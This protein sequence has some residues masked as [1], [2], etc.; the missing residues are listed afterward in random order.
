M[1]LSKIE[2]FGFKSFANKTVINF[3]EGIT[4]IVGP[5]GCG[6]TNIVDAVRWVLGEQKTS[7][8]RSEVMENV[9][10]NGSATRKPQGMAEVSIT[11]RNDKGLLP[12]HFTE[13][14]VT[15]KLFR[16]GKSE[17]FI[18]NNQ[19]RLK[20]IQDLFIDKGLGS[21]SYSI[22][23]L[24]MIETLLNGSIEDRRRLLE[25]SA[26]ISKYKQRKKET[27]K[28]LD[29]VQN[30]LLRIYDIVNEI[31][32]Q[33]RSLSRQAAKTKRY[34]KIYQELKALELD[35]WLLQFQ[36]ANK[37]VETLQKENDDLNG[38]RIVSE[39]E[40]QEINEEIDKLQTQISDFEEKLEDVRSE[41][42]SI[43]KEYANLQNQINLAQE[44]INSI[45]ATEN[46][47][48][49]EVQE[50]NKLLE[51]FNQTHKELIIVENKK[52][53]ESDRLKREF[54]EVTIGFKKIEEEINL[55]RKKLQELREKVFN[56]ENELKY[57]GLN[58]QRMNS[59]VSQS[60]ERKHKL[61]KEVESIRTNVNQK[62]E[63]IE[64][65]KIETNK[66]NVELTEL[67]NLLK[68]KQVALENIKTVRD[69]FYQKQNEL[70]LALREIQTS[71]DFL[72]SVLEVDESTRFLIKE[73]DW[74][75]DR[76]FFL[77]GEILPIEEQFRIAYDSLL[78]QFKNVIIVEKE[79]DIEDAKVVLSKNHKG[80]CIFVCL[81][82]VP[83]EVKEPVVSSHPKII[84]VAS[85]IPNVDQRLR[86]V[87]RLILGNSVIAKD[88]E[89]ALEIVKDSEVQSVV[90]LS[91]EMIWGGSIQKR[92][93]ILRMEGLSIG[94]VER[95]KKLESKSE[96]ILSELE[97]IQNKI[98]QKDQEI[99][100][101]SNE[102]KK[103]TEKI[104]QIELELNQKTIL[105]N[106][107]E[108]LLENLRK[109]LE[110]KVK[111]IEAIEIESE[112]ISLDVEK[113]RSSI[114]EKENLLSKLKVKLKQ[115][116][117]EFSELQKL[118]QS[119]QTKFRD[120]E[121]QLV[122]LNT[123]LEGLL[124]EIQ[125]IEN[126]R[127]HQQTKLVKLKE[128]Y[129]RLISEKQEK[130]NRLAEMT[131][132]IEQVE[133]SLEQVKQRKGYFQQQKRELEELL[134]KQ[135][136]YKEQIQNALEKL[137]AKVYQNEIEIARQKEI[138]HSLFTKALENYQVNLNDYLLSSN[139]EEMDSKEIEFKIAELRKSLSS[140][141]NVN[142]LALQEYE[143]QKSRLELYRTQI[144]DLVQSEKSLKQ[145]L[146]EIN[147][148]AEKRFLE[149]F[150]QVNQNFG[151]VYQEL[152]GRDSF[153]EL[154]I[155]YENPLD[156]DIEIKV[157]PAGKKV[158]SIETLSQ[159]EKTLTVLSLLFALYLVKPSPFCILDE[160]DAPLDDANVDRFL[161][162]LKR[163]SKDVQFILIT[164][165]KR[166]MEFANTLYGVTMAEDG[167]S[168]V[169]SVKLVE[170]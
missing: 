6:K 88:F 128:E 77:L 40:L 98:G 86:N 37:I 17:Y 69:E 165:N 168:K 92:G 110:N 59:G 60:A 97:E 151:K 2:L 159:G 139:L 47:V 10:F 170:S 126:S 13:L 152:F 33:V 157:K 7:L 20:D 94:K 145:A 96:Q 67:S 130:A 123:E 120:I 107:E 8:L 52:K 63:Y 43:F 72:N 21:N 45:Q 164:H 24:K 155:D 116:E 132:Q 133:Q 3:N 18:N 166:T 129:S 19:C 62:T 85:E 169:L 100:A 147:E 112:K 156:S 66:L 38:K 80:K 55:K 113:V 42:N 91:G 54:E 12:S 127:M 11:F 27:T 111:S 29:N 143:E 131:K 28:K 41:E 99:D 35:F 121:K 119:E 25:E 137:T 105:L 142:F 104:K 34:N 158:N 115:K 61:L 154:V 71:L 103:L 163:F 149:T 1:F 101:I 26:G 141:G 114:N 109:D 5:N 32:Q 73:S 106:R 31:E 48:H 79:S 118:Y 146:K 14:T 153:A 39:K 4:A 76:K 93:T 124:T 87:L 78:G 58:L 57:E 49:L 82:N 160:V 150:E 23:E 74:G 102:I 84:G 75:K 125:R 22:I 44:R 15:R 53:E 135:E 136:E 140:L 148:T 9:I 68:E 161:N 138:A 83:S 50:V 36:N 16:D 162:L 117:D 89:D 81:E 65:Q 122:K 30:D 144:E 70:Q 108:L 90:T 134:F 51:R 56:I 46:K 64:K 167:I 95:I